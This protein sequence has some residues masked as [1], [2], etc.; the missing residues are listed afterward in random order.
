MQFVL[1]L[2]KNSMFLLYALIVQ[3]WNSSEIKYTIL[4]NYF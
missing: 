1:D 3:F 4:N 2:G